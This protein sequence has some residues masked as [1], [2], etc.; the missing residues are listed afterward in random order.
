MPNKSRDI[1]YFIVALVIGLIWFFVSVFFT[2][3]HSKKYR[4]QYESQTIET[5]KNI[6]F[7]G[8]ILSIYKYRFKGETHIYGIMR[9]KL[10]YSNVDSFY[11]FNDMN[12]LKISN[13]IATLP[14]SVL[15]LNSTIGRTNA[16]L[17]AVYIEVNMNNDNQ[18]TYIDSLGNQFSEDLNFPSKTVI[19][20][21]FFDRISSQSD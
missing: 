5:F 17:K 21:N 4:D 7:K 19:S 6:K 13:G 14:T 11:V 1:K 15:F 9:V 8:K 20:K 3:Q 16:I 2:C 12:C 10:D 18:T